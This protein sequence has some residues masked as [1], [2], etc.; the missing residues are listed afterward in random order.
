MKQILI[1]SF[2]L[3]FVGI[4]Y[5]QQGKQDPKYLREANKAFDAKN[6][7]DAIT[8]CQDAFKKL[9]TKG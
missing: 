6:Y 5:S 4:S 2:S 7:F 9:G 8:K 3:F 1:L